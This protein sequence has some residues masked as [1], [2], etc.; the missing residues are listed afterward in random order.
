MPQALTC[1]FLSWSILPSLPMLYVQWIGLSTSLSILY[2]HELGFT[3]PTGPMHSLWPIRPLE[4][5]LINF[6][7]LCKR[8]SL[9]RYKWINELT[10]ACH[11]WWYSH[12]RFPHALLTMNLYIWKQEVWYNRWSHCLQCWHPL[13]V[14]VQEL[15]VPLLIQIS[16]K[17]TGE[18]A[19]N[20]LATHRGNLVGVS[21]F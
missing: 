20:G 3:M 11:E 12:L 13:W 1:S 9:C 16:A 18:M 15:A 8:S 17:I 19:Q 7:L 21:S 6:I 2:F 5:T 14:L 4:H 10:Q